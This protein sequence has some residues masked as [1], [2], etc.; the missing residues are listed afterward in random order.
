MAKAKF[1]WFDG[2]NRV[3]K[4]SHGSIDRTTQSNH[5]ATA[6]NLRTVP[7]YVIFIRPIRSESLAVKRH[8]GLLPSGNTHSGTAFHSLAVRRYIYEAGSTSAPV[9]AY[10]TISIASVTV[11]TSAMKIH[12]II[13]YQCNFV[14]I[15]IAKKVECIILTFDRYYGYEENLKIAERI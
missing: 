11:M 14:R 9:F 4:S 12:S 6:K 10:Y 13:W 1:K 3:K 15:S 5:V 8:S 2:S 7:V